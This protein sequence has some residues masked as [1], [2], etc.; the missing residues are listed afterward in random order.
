MIAKLKAAAAAIT[1]ALA[2]PAGVSAKEQINI[3]IC[4]SW[5][6]YAM[7]EIAREKGLADDY[8]INMVIFDDPLGGHAA[9]A[10]GQIDIY[11]CTGDYTPLAIERGSGVVSVAF[12]NPSYGVDHIILAPDI[13]PSNMKGK[14]IGAPQAYIGQLLM[15]VWLDSKGVS[16]D[17]VEWV[18]LLADE[19]VGPML[20]GDLAAAYLYEPWIT[21]VME[22][23]PGSSSAVHTADPDMLKTGIFMDVVYM[24]GDFLSNRRQAALD[25]MK[26]RFDALGWWNENTAEGNEILSKFL[27]WPL[28]DVES[29]IGTNGKFLDGGIYMYDFNESAQVCG[30]LEG[31]PPFEIGNGSMEQVVSNINEWWVR[32]GLMKEVHDSSAGVDCSLMAELVKGGYTQSL[33]AND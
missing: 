10:A 14:R 4:V 11:E 18:N 27:K 29:V 15:G 20:S 5:P 19:A 22:N 33:K 30:V 21:K 24:N 28:A 8:D 17:D 3:G 32:L 31:E 1:M 6:G 7:H 2:V 13:D 9:L 26:A 25:M 16:L 23:L 12:A